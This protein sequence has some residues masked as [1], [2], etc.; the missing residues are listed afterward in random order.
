MRGIVVAPGFDGLVSTQVIIPNYL[1]GPSNCVQP[2]GNLTQDLTS[3]AT[4]YVRKLP[5][6]LHG[7]TH[8]GNES[9]MEWVSP[10]WDDLGYYSICRLAKLR[11][12]GS[13]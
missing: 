13:R 5:Q 7:W 9:D 2:S 6:N 11:S 3:L 1:A 12:A 10:L 4:C 8:E